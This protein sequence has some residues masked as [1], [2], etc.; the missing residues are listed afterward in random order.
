LLNDLQGVGIRTRLRPLERAAFLKAYGEK[1]LKNIIYS[2]SGVAGNAATR[3][4]TY[5]VSG[6]SYA[7]GGYPDVDGLFREQVS[8]L[9]ARKRET[10]LRRIQQLVHEKAMFLPVWQYV[11]PQGA[12]PRVAEPGLGL[13]TDYPWSAPYEDLQLKGK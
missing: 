10:I 4:E 2:L 12:G 7:Y 13:I 9:D 6:G 1:K 3:I 11:V 8:E 5:V